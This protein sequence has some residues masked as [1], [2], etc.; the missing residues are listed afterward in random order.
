MGDNKT[1]EKFESSRQTKDGSTLDAHDKLLRESETPMSSATV[2]KNDAGQIDKIY[3]P[4]K[5]TREL[6]YD[7]NGQIAKISGVSWKNT[8]DGEHRIDFELT[9]KG[10]VGSSWNVYDNREYSGQFGIVRSVEVDQF[11]NIK[12]NVKSS[13]D[14]LN[15][16]LTLRND[17]TMVKSRVVDS[18]SDYYS[19]EKF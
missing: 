6:S 2:H 14:R 9:S 4:D 1:S 12:L 16:T 13:A 11:G 8:S 15:K 10:K 17:G 3:L 7:Q 18:L 5:H 19:D